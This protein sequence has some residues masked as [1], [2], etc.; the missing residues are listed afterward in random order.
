MKKVIIAIIAAM[1]LIPAL[2]YAQIVKGSKVKGSQELFSLGYATLMQNEE[3]YWLSLETSNRYDVNVNIRLGSDKP[4]AIQSL[5][6]LIDIYQDLQVNDVQYIQ[7]GFG[8][9]FRTYKVSRALNIAGKD[10]AGTANITPSELKRFI[11]AL[12]RQ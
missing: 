8:E 5:N 4:S 11:R 9:T 1:T 12:K 6:D 2:S 10:Y 3:C 7:S